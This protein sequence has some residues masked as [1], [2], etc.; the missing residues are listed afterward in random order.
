MQPAQ[1]Y[2][3]QPAAQY[4]Q[5]AAHYAQ[6]AAQPVQHAAPDVAAAPVAVAPATGQMAVNVT[7]TKN[8]YK[9][10]ASGETVVSDVS[11]LLGFVSPNP[12]LR[13][14]I[15]ITRTFAAICGFREKASLV[16]TNNRVVVDVRKYILWV[17]ES[18]CD[19]ITIN[20]ANEILT[21]YNSTL[22]IFKKRYISVDN[23]LIGV[24]GKV[25]QQDLEGMSTVLQSMI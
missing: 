21:G 3:Q 1:P 25:T 24:K 13:T 9:W 5:P 7:R 14:I 2:P 11:G 10:L 6:P 15:A 17:I 8:N 16:V 19:T 20:K 22:L 23:Y 18:G 4:A 12:L